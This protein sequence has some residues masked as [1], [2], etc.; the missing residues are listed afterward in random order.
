MFAYDSPM[1]TQQELSVTIILYN[2][3]S[4]IISHCSVVWGVKLTTP[5]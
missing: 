5:L 2:S 4:N 1:A 3:V